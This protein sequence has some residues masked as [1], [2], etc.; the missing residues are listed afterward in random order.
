MLI[1]WGS[2]LAGGLHRKFGQRNLN[3][4]FG[5]TDREGPRGAIFPAVHN[6]PG[7]DKFPQILEAAHRFHHE[8]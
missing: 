5:V 1:A 2:G 4:W 7:N 3:V 6:S 8:G